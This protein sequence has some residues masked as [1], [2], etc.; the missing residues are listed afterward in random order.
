MQGVAVVQEA[1]ASPAEGVQVLAAVE[2]EGVQVLAAVEAE[3]VQASVADSAVPG[4]GSGQVGV[5][6]VGS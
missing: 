2:A 4:W 1:Q 3:E 5:T 6:V